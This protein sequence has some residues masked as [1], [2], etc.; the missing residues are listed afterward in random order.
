MKPVSLRPVVPDRMS[1]ILPSYTTLTALFRLWPLG[2]TLLLAG[3]L[4]F[5][6]LARESLWLDEATTI[7][8]ARQSLLEIVS[9]AA[10]DV[11]P[12]L[13]YLLMHGW[14]LLG[15]SETILRAFSVL[16]GLLTVPLIYGLAL[17]LF[18]RRV[19]LL[20]A[21][22]LALSPLHV[23]YS[24][25]ARMYVL[26]AF[27][28]C[29]ASWVL[30][31]IVSQRKPASWGWLLGYALLMALSFYTHYITL[32]TPV[33][34][35]FYVGH[36]A[37]RRQ[38]S[39][40]RIKGWLAGLVGAVVLFLPWLPTF[41]RQTFQGSAG[42]IALVA[43]TPTL[44]SLADAA[45]DFTVGPGG[46]YPLWLGR[47]GLV[48]A[49]GLGLIALV[50]SQ[51]LSSAVPSPIVFVLLYA[52]GT[53]GIV[54]LV[55][56]VRPV[57]LSRYLLVFLPGFILLLARGL[58]AL[59]RTWLRLSILAALLLLNLFSLRHV[60][61]DAQKPD[62]RSASAYIQSI[63]ET[64]ESPIF[65]LPGWDAKALAYYADDQ[66]RIIPGPIV[67]D[68]EE[69]LAAALAEA[70]DDGTMPLWVVWARPYPTR[71]QVERT[72]EIAGFKPEMQQSFYGIEGITLYV[73]RPGGDS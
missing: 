3:A 69:E 71:S 35:A 56:Q 7:V 28:V 9:Q 33:F 8:V 61:A 4:R 29:G 26:A 57:F 68:G 48:L 13:Y 42:W 1:V 12:P 22:L 10:T 50:R 27:F 60:Y 62:W 24:Q 43:G 64:S 36:V 55:S 17:S 21:F 37:S 30:V 23:T 63:P 45:M 39:R 46:T 52:W 2:G 34:H 67:E 20:A 72:L 38:L 73:F 14:L 25:E 49:L 65:V 59:P 51:R 53:L 19:G 40:H 5:Y 31:R 66:R 11:H 41:L 70:V 44:T 32:F 54:W 58:D 47:I 16:V 6:A 18:N 15:E